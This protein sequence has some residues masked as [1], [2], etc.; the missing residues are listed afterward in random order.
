M[1]TRRLWLVI[2]AVVAVSVFCRSVLAQQPQENPQEEAAL[3]KGAEAFVEAFH[4]GDAKAV[5]AFWTPDGDYMDQTG[6]H[7][8]GRQAIEEAF[9][10]FFAENKG[11][12]LRIEIASIR[13]V[14]PEMAIEDGTTE[15][16]P[17]DGGP[18]SRARYTNVHVKKGAKWYLASVRSAP[19]VPPNNYEQLR[20]LDW[21]I[22][23]W[24]SDPDKG[25]VSR[26]SFA[27]SP[28]QN[29]IVSSHAVAFKDIFLGS[30]TQ[31][32]GWDPAANRIRSWTFEADGG[33]GEGSWTKQ[34]GQWVIKTNSV[35]RDGKKLAATNVVTPVD[36]N[37]IT[38]QSKDRSVDGKPLP[39][40]QE[41]RMKRV[42]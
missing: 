23:E 16:I 22:G 19:L 21:A 28:E 32:I 27:W 5:A 29:F 8:K 10:G 25:E 17:P 34:G 33:F 15:V 7:L 31:R 40:T 38:W 3:L 39:D 36:A 30:G 2:L 14:T 24:A 6:K 26:A 4:K 1:R 42:K 18:P 37:T 9:Q 13:V 20:V 35:L 12:K 11:M 41:I